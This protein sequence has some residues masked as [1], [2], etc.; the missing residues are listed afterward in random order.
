MTVQSPAQTDRARQVRVL[1]M[2]ASMHGATAEIAAV[3]GEELS[4]QGLAA[5]VIPRYQKVGPRHR[6]R[7]HPGIPVIRRAGCNAYGRAQP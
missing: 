1:I 7:T 2:V 6:A 4:G 3:L 5:T